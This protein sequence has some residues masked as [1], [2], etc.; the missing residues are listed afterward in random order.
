MSPEVDPLGPDYVARQIPLREGGVATLVRYQPPGHEGDETGPSARRA[1]LFVHGYVDYF[2]HTHVAEHFAARGYDFYALDLRRSGRS[3]RQG[4]APFFFSDLEEFD[5]EL[6]AAV[7]LI[8]GDGHTRLTMLGSSTG[9]L[10]V[11]LWLDR[12][13]GAVPVEAVV[14]NSPWLDLQEPWHMRT[15]G[16]HVLYGVG[17]F[18]PHFI[19]PQ[20]IPPGYVASIHVSKK[21]EWDF[22]TDWKPLVGAPTYAGVV[23][24]VRRGHAKVHRGL[25]LRVPVL[26]MHSDRSLKLRDWQPAAQRADCVLDVKQMTK[27]APKLGSDVTDVTIP[28]GLHDLFLSEKSVRDRVF[29]EMDAWLDEVVEQAGHRL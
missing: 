4:D 13:G 27:W 1:V 29:A 10:V 25:K 17:Q 23:A 16:T 9:G 22:N 11:C 8:R 5:E 24:A 7:E 26:V 15:F 14:L 18:A 28:G 3:L 2:F 19:L 20:G 21:G 12:R 6:D